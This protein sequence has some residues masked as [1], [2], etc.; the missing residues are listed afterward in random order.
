MS[1]FH[2]LEVGR[3]RTFVEGSD[4]NDWDSIVCSVNAG[5]QR[6]GKRITGLSLDVVSCRVTD[7]SSTMLGDVVI[8]HRVREALEAADLTGFTLR[9]ADVS[10]VPR[11]CDRAKLPKLWEFVVVGRGGPAHPDSGIE[12][13]FECPGCGLVRYSAF[14]NGIIVDTSSYDGSDFFTVMEYPK[15]I[16]VSERAKGVI[17]AGGFTNVGFVESTQLTWPEGVVKPTG[18]SVEN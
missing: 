3:D 2:E 5:H 8:T 18:D 12:K 9:H 7:F 1:V 14:K 6:A 15:Y 17:E 4:A 10:K 16:L 11:R 13:L